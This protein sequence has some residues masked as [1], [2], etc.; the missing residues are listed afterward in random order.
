MKITSVAV[1]TEKVQC[2]KDG[3]M[4]WPD[5]CPDVRIGIV[6]FPNSEIE[7]SGAYEE[8]YVF[9]G[10]EQTGADSKDG[11]IGIHE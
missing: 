8:V 4:R 5:R 7:H 6:A 1:V 3:M 9:G 10:C 11:H 2:Y